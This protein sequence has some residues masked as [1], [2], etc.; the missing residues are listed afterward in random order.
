M[1]ITNPGEAELPPA[2]ARPHNI[3]VVERE[4]PTVPEACFFADER[5]AAALRRDAEVVLDLPLACAREDGLRGRLDV[6][7]VAVGPTPL[8]EHAVWK[9]AARGQLGTSSE[10]AVRSGWASSDLRVPIPL[11]LLGCS[12]SG[13]V[14]AAA[15]FNAGMRAA[16]PSI[17]GLPVAVP[18]PSR[19]EAQALFSGEPLPRTLRF[20]ASLHEL[21]RIVAAHP[22]AEE[23]ELD[24]YLSASQG[25]AESR[26]DGRTMADRLIELADELQA[27]KDGTRPT[28]DD[29]AGAPLLENWW[30]DTKP[31][32]I[33]KGEVHGHP[34]FPA[35]R[36]IST[37]D[38]YATDG[39][40]FLRTL[41]R[42]YRL[43]RP[44][45]GIPARPH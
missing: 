33:V 14:P 20:A 26:R 7:L 21:L 16:L 6:A 36:L 12:R 5:I 42:W 34:N 1:R 10:A 23:G 39:T 35:G 40:T 38:L 22:H 11:R 27:I 8:D 43:G 37:S 2:A 31:L 29:L 44:A 4:I 24:V 15:A 41:S 45:G 28:A 9:A 17:K 25:A 13:G 32:R 3:E 19:A 30:P 18:T